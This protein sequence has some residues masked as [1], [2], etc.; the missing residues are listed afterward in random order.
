MD[1]PEEIEVVEVGDNEELGASGRKEEDIFIDEDVE[2]FDT[3]LLGEAIEAARG[4]LEVLKDQGRDTCGVFKSFFHFFS[5]GQTPHCPKFVEW[6]ADNFSVAEGVIMNKS[7]S[8]I[9]CLVQASV[10]RRTL[11]IQDEFIHIS[12]D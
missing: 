11:H 2:I 8:K 9:L 3:I 12:Q 6:C 5:I 4:K 10:I 1:R 7:R